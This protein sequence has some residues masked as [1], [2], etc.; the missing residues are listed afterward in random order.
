MR[1]LVTLGRIGPG[2]LLGVIC[3]FAVTARAQHHSF[4]PGSDWG[5]VLPDGFA[6]QD[7]P[8]PHFSHP[9][10]AY[11]VAQTLYD[12]LDDQGLGPVGSLLGD[13]AQAIRIVAFEDLEIANGRMLLWT[14]RNEASGDL[15]LMAFADGPDRIPSLTAVITTGSAGDPDSLCAALTSVALRAVPD[16]E[17]LAIFP[18]LVGDLGGF[19]IARFAPDTLLL[20]RAGAYA[21]HAERDGSSITITPKARHPE[22]RLVFPDTIATMREMVESGHPGGRQT[23]SDI[24]QTGLGQAVTTRFEFTQPTGRLVQGKTVTMISR[25]CLIIALGAFA[26]ND[27]EAEARFQRVWQSI[28][29]RN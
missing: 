19:T 14:G 11:I 9:D 21:G 22:E 26:S 24:I 16:V 13:G 27:P 25:Y 12:P 7:F 20:T 15:T 29:S 17:R 4:L 5:L 28:R 18:V 1:V 6:Q 8:I 23:G 3:A 10:R 2:L